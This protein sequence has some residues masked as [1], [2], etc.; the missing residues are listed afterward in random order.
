MDDDIDVRGSAWLTSPAEEW[1]EDEELKEFSG[2]LRV[3]NDVAERGIKLVQDFLASVTNDEQQLQDVMQVV[4]KHRKQI[5][6]FS[7]SAVMKL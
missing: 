1:E 7:K 6:S 3:T 4:E 2:R 5:S